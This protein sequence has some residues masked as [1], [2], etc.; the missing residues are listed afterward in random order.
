ME[1]A[2]ITA[3][4]L[5]KTLIA[6]QQAK[7]PPIKLLTLDFL[8]EFSGQST[9]E[10]EI[11]LKDWV[12]QVVL[13]QVQQYR[14]VEERPFLSTF[15]DTKKQIISALAADFSHNNPELEAWS[16]LFHRYCIPF[17]MSVNDLAYAAA[18]VPR[19]FSRRVQTGI[20][21]L[22]DQIRR[23][24]IQTH[25]RFLTQQKRRFLPPPE[26]D[27]LFGSKPLIQQLFQWMQ[28]KSSPRV[29]SIEGLGG[30]GKTALARAF[31]NELAESNEL[32]GII[33]ISARHEWLTD[34][35]KV[36]SIR[37]PARSLA[38]IVTR[39]ADQLGQ[40]E[41]SGF[42]VEEKLT[43]LRPIL[44]N[45]SYFI[46]IDNLETIEDVSLLIPA[47]A[48]LMETTRIL[49]TSRHSLSDYD[50]IHRFPVPPLQQA[51]SRTLIESELARRGRNLQLN[52]TTLSHFHRIIGGVPLALKL[53]AAQL[54]YLP[55]SDVLDGLQNANRQS[56]QHLFTYIYRLTWQLLDEPAKVLLL[57]L[58]SISPDGEGAEWMQL[59]SGLSKH[60][61][62]LALQQLTAYSLL[63]V[64]S[65]SE[66]PIYRMHRLTTTFLQTE[67]LLNWTN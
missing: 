44:A 62:D 48:S 7:S 28:Q 40:T 38:D 49:L 50:F 30:I 15:P 34:Q 67:I 58:L 42:S 17:S 64:A 18:I 3:P 13:E 45:S 66:A 23:K 2:E 33:W 19:Q 35:G 6:F 20:D 4:L 59:M 63:E 65:L 32:D 53:I 14:K 37:D 21:L 54:A 24:E 43:R 26:Y 41:L 11:F 9:A 1:I 36:Q 29:I 5:K 51:D 47:L 12:Q 8:H 60:K 16:A 55:L 22:V 57:S 10:K 39:L 56:S 46:I 27:Q 52:Q 61:F 31:A 25:G